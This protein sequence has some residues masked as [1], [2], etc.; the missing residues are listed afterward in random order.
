MSDIG[1]KKIFIVAGARPN[2][3][4]VAPIMR[5]MAESPSLR[6]ILVHTGQHYDHNMSQSFFDELNIP[7]PDVFLEVGSGSHAAQTAAVMIAFEKAVLELKP[8]LVLVVGDVNSTLACSLV[9]AKLM[10]PVAHVE[11]GLRSFDRSMPEEINRVLTDSIS[12]FLFVTEPS[13]RDNLLREGVAEDNIFFVGNVM[14]DTLAENARRVRNGEAVRPLGD[15]SGDYAALTLHRPSNVDDPA[16]FSR[17]ISALE[18]TAAEAPVFFPAHPRTVNNIRRFGLDDH[19]AAWDGASTP[20]GKI[21]IMEPLG[22]L[23]FLSL[24]MNAKIV[25]TDSGGIQEETTWLGVP[26]ATIREN[27]ERPVTVDVGTNILV[28]SDAGKISAA[29]AAALRGDWKKGSIPELWDGHAA[30]RIVSKLESLLY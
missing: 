10:I 24:T 17:I 12:S 3:V 28:G 9:S 7:R 4:K 30:P 25:L 29:A 8:D 13:G 5:A 19:F 2:F 15:F 16:T 23:E 11:A 14:I 6:P 20:A 1:K 18:A 21:F 22:Y 27:T 26:C